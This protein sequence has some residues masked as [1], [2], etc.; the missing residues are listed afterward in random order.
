MAAHPY[1]TFTEHLEE[2]RWRLVKSVG[3]VALAFGLCYFQSDRI[4]GFMIAPLKGALQPGQNLIGTGVTEAFFIEMKV[5]L[6]GGLFLASPVIFY[7]I[8]RF[9]APG[10]LGEEK[11]MV[12]P[13]VLCATGFFVGGA[14]F[15]Y[16]VVLPVAFAYFVDQY[17][18]LGVAPE[19]RIG[20]YFSFFFR[21]ILA[22]G[23]T[24][25]LPVFTFFLV[26]LGIVDYRLM[27]RS[28]RYAIVLIFIA[29]AI[30]T[31]T[32]DVIN[33]TLLAAPM[34][35]LYLLSI[36]VAYIWRKERAE[37]PEERK[38]P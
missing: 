33:Q 31:P 9:L 38:D 8:W 2:L 10:L 19:I 17:L 5:G 13:F 15:C 20:E 27:W 29:A 16:R 6:V 26:R 30:L 12:V 3:A 34:L 24:F 18:S 25:E 11:K 37:Q 4:F 28:F 23:V 22:F 32:P 1:M 35:I 36:G 7:Q 21:M 14:Y